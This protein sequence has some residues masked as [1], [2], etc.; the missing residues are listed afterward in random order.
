MKNFIVGC[1]RVLIDI[2]AW[3]ILLAIL[4]FGIVLLFQQPLAGLGVLIIGTIVFVSVFYLLY[5][6]IDI[7]DKLDIIVENQIKNKEQQ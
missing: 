5:L 1:G 6:F 4:I 3:I 2:G 7:K